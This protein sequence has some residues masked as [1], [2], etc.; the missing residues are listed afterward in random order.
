MV[1]EAGVLTPRIAVLIVLVDCM[2]RRGDKV[3]EEAC[4]YDYFNID[5]DHHA[6]T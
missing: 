5:M 2:Q 3:K 6:V 1:K 4:M